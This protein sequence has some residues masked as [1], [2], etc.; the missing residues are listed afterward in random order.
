MLLRLIMTQAA[1]QPAEIGK[2][3]NEDV[4]AHES[5]KRWVSGFTQSFCQGFGFF[6]FLSVLLPICL[7]HSKADSSYGCRIATSENW[8]I[9]FLAYSLRKK[10]LVSKN[11]RQKS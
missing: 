5:L 8:P 7:L 6:L 1:E 2:N 3:N 11:S 4:L 10:E 9:Y